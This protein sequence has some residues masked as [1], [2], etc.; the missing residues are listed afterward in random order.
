[1]GNESSATPQSEEADVSLEDTLHSL[2]ALHG[3]DEFEKTLKSVIE[4]VKCGPPQGS[5]SVESRDRAPCL[6]CVDSASKY[7]EPA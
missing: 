4:S 3:A 2:V 6:Q 5:S 7:F 1:M